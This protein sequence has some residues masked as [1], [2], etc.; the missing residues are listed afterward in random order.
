MICHAYPDRVADQGKNWAWDRFYYGLTPSLRDAL[1]FSM[2][3]LPE[4]EQAGASFDTLYTLAKK[5]EAHQPNRMHHGQGSSD[6]YR[7]RYR[8]YPTP[9]ERV[10]TLAKEELLLPDPEPL[11]PGVP[12]LD[13]IEGLSL[14]MIQAMNHYQREE[15]QCFMCGVTYHFARDCPHR[16]SFHLLWKEQLN[17]QGGGSQPKETIKPS[18]DIN[19]HVATMCD[20]P[21]MIAS[22]PMAHWAGPETLVGLWVEG[23]EVNTLVNSGSQVN[24]VMPNYVH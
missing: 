4:R 9:E 12:E 24:T 18:M 14:R 7:D 6:A 13:V 15:C 19:A 5:M 3:E 8:R 16:D 11:D 21:S 23:R 20:T 1:E 2:V 17:S 10:A 22:G